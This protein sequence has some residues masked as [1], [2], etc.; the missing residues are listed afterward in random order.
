MKELVSQ[1]DPTNLYWPIL[2][3]MGILLQPL[4]S[5]NNVNNNVDDAV[6][7]QHRRG[8]GITKIITHLANKS[9]PLFSKWK[10][11]D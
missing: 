4:I 8:P 2:F 11:F 1:V 3:A 5:S 9:I 7:H 6:S 10:K